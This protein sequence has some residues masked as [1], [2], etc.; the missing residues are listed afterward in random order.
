[1]NKWRVIEYQITI[2]ISEL[3]TFRDNLLTRL[4]V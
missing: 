1:M 3:L 2:G 4:F